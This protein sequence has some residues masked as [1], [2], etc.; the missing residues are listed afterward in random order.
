MKSQKIPALP[1]ECY[2]KPNWDN[3]RW[4]AAQPSNQTHKGQVQGNADAFHIDNEWLHSNQ[5]FPK[6]WGLYQLLEAGSK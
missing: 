2:L 5:L 6:T 4:P 3:Y 1:L